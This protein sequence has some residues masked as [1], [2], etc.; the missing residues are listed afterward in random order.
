MAVGLVIMSERELNRIEVPS[1]VTRGT[2]TPVTAANMLGLSR[3]QVHRLPKDFHIDGPAAIRHK[4]RGRRSNNRIDPA[5][6][7]FAVTVIPESYIDFGPSLAAEMLAEQHGF[8]ISC[9]TV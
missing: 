5:V 9:K 1:Q 6:R 7:G 8:E 3:R 2:M 4:A